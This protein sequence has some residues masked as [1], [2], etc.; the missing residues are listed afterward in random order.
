M[1]IATITLDDEGYTQQYPFSVDYRDQRLIK[2]DLDVPDDDKYFPDGVMISLRRDIISRRGLI[3]IKLG[4]IENWVYIGQEHR[5]LSGI[6][7]Q[8]ESVDELRIVLDEKCFVTGCELH[9]G[10]SMTIV[11]GS[12]SNI[13]E[14]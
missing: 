12:R 13:H 1:N 9:A 8:S 7:I 3:S 2:F 5:Y 4:D 10:F 11:Y 14:P 6:V